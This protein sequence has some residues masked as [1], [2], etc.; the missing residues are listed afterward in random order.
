MFPINIENIIYLNIF[1]L[2][3]ENNVPPQDIIDYVQSKNN[4][5]KDLLNDVIYGN[6]RQYDSIIVLNVL[7]YIADYFN[8]TVDYILGLT[9]RPYC[10]GIQMANRIDCSITENYLKEK[11]R[12]LQ[13]NDDGYCTINCSACPFYDNFHD[14]IGSKEVDVNCE[15]YDTLYPTECIQ[16][17][18]KW[19]DAHPRKTYKDDFLE[20]FPKASKDK[21]GYP[22]TNPRNIYNDDTMSDLCSVDSSYKECWDLPMEG[23]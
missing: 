23:V 20:K 16:A 6:F 15:S 12:A 21:D 9:N 22:I 1:H 8:T 3:Q 13:P 5:D 2:M 4:L 18:Q 10:G 14:N 11:A 17:I 7:I 19:S